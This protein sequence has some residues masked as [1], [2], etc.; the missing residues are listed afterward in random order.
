MNINICATLQTRRTRGAA[1]CWTYLFRHRT[2][3]AE[4]EPDLRE[5]RTQHKHKY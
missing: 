1:A 5:M 2:Q 4:H 3:D